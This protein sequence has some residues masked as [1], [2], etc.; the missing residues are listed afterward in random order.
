VGSGVVTVD[1]SIR[2]LFG[3][4]AFHLDR[5]PAVEVTR[6]LGAPTGSEL[7]DPVALVVPS[8]PKRGRVDL[9][10]VSSVDWSGMVVLASAHKRALASSGADAAW[11]RVE[12]EEARI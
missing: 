4:L 1:L 11:Y 9:G 3:R 6:N 7:R 5:G 12:R 10:L 8:G 2:R